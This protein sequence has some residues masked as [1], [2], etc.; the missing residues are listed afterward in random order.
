MFIPKNKRFSIGNKLKLIEGYEIK[1]DE[2]V[3]YGSHYF[4]IE[5]IEEPSPMHE[6][7]Y[8]LTDME[9]GYFVIVEETEL[10]EK[11]VDII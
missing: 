11:F 7:E 1:I 10:E 4:K 2:G 5:R 8:H 9:C 3:F 6:K